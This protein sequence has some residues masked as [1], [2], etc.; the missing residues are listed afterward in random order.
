MNYIGFAFMVAG[1]SLS[2]ATMIY[3]WGIT[4]DNWL[5]IIFGTTGSVS[6]MG[7]ANLFMGTEK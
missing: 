2:F 5:W 4:P 7:I 6:L 3:G 1:F